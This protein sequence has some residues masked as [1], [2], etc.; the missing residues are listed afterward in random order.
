MPAVVL[1]LNPPLID[2]PRFLPKKALHEQRNGHP[3]RIP[4]RGQ[5]QAI[6]EMLGGVLGDDIISPIVAS[7]IGPSLGLKQLCELFYLTSFTEAPVYPGCFSP[8]FQQEKATLPW[9]ICVIMGNDE[10]DTTQYD[11]S[12]NREND[13]QNNGSDQGNENHAAKPVAQP[14]DNDTP[15]K[16]PRIIHEGAWLRRAQRRANSQL[17]GHILAVSFSDDSVTRPMSSEAVYS[18]STSTNATYRN[19]RSLRRLRRFAFSSMRPGPIKREL[20]DDSRGA[21]AQS[22]A[23]PPLNDEEQRCMIAIQALGRVRGIRNG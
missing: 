9:S 19:Q 5:P 13:N 14:T 8:H 22:I 7:S 4:D 10:K 12:H 16:N 21:A 15:A 11:Q 18:A 20:G 23:A 3:L 1:C 2:M 6:C 17:T